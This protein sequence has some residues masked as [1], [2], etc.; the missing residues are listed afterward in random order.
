MENTQTVRLQ[1]RGGELGWG[2]RTESQQQNIE[3]K[4]E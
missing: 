2:Q 3:V 1:G 4:S